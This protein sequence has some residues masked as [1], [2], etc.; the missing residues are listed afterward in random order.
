[1]LHCLAGVDEPDGGWVEVAGERMSHR[2]ESERA[3]LR[4]RR[5]GVILQSGN[6]LQDL[7]VQSNLLLTATLGGGTANDV[8]LNLLSELGVAEKVDAFPAQLSGGEAARVALA[9]S[10]VNNPSVLLADEPTGEL[11]AEN[12]AT[13]LGLLRER[14][15]A[16][17]AV[18]VVTH[19]PAM[20]TA[21]D[22][23]L[24]LVDGR[25]RHE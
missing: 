12:E 19:N 16:G 9:L 21:A 15:A 20:S 23:T 25:I 10:L 14:A 6:L 1:L 11:D 4:A 2:T 22:R 18:V 5:I 17:L 13:V 3:H 8:A 24:Q 7:T